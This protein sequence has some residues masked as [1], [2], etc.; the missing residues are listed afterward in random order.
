MPIEYYLTTSYNSTIALLTNALAST[1][2]DV[3][4]N[5]CFVSLAL[6]E[7]MGQQNWSSTPGLSC[8]LSSYYDNVDR[9]L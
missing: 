8:R 3:F 1:N 2:D 7:P 9:C 4:Y 5:L 6:W